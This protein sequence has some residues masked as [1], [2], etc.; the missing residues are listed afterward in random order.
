MAT[1]VGDKATLAAASLASGDYIVVIDTSSADVRI[2]Q[3]ADLLSV[4]ET[5][6]VADTTAVVKGSADATKQLRFEVDGFTSGATRVLTPPNANATI[7]G[8]EVAQTFTAAQTVAAAGA[9]V[10]LTDADGYF[11]A[12]PAEDDQNIVFQ[13]V[14][15]A[16]AGYGLQKVY[17]EYSTNDS[18]GNNSFRVVKVN[19]AGTELTQLRFDDDGWIFTGV[20]IT[21]T[22]V[23]AANSHVRIGAVG[24]GGVR[25][26]SVQSGTAPT[27][28]PTDC[29]QMWAADFAPGDARFY[30]RTEGGVTTEVA[31]LALANTWT[32]A[33][34][35]SSNSASAFA[36]GP[37][38]D[39]NPAFRVAANVA[40]A[41]TGIAVTGNAA[42]SHATISVISS[43]ANESLLLA[44]KGT[45]G[46]LF[47]DGAL[48]TPSIAFST[49]TNVG[50]FQQLAGTVVFVA[51]GTSYIQFSNAG[52]LA[53]GSNMTLGFCSGQPTAT[54]P[55]VGL[56]RDAAG[57]C[58]VSNGSTGLGSL[59]TETL[60]VRQSGGVAGTDEVQLSHDGA[61]AY[62]ESKDGPVRIRASTM[63]ASCYW[64]LSAVGSTGTLT[65]IGSGSDVTI[66]SE[67]GGGVAAT[68]FR[69]STNNFISFSATTGFVM[70]GS[71]GSRDVG[72]IRNEAGVWRVSNASTGLGS[73]LTG[74]L[75]EA[76]TAGSGSPNV[77]TAN[78]S[79]KTL[80]NEGATAQNYHTLPSAAAG[81][82]FEFI[83]QDA[84]G[85][86]VVAAAGDTIRDVGTVSAAAGYIQSTTVG[87]VVRLRAI[88]A[89]EWFVVYKQGTWTIDS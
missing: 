68:M 57:V 87:S 38:G 52:K 74:T 69:D 64:E 53:L 34:V 20:T 50:F 5:P 60:T 54:N 13:A 30:M 49:A 84:D 58:R 46:V 63:T 79:R 81:Y 85:I 70:G 41:A 75:V 77:L 19:S 27:T 40:S 73:L 51:G 2:V 48:S 80:T 9:A 89:T 7:A 72:L 67:S 45:G 11:E 71:G 47:P 65:Y 28:S 36:V 33:Q 59:L 44:P 4:I 14:P 23:L 78:E 18:A 42:G 37:N 35:I 25:V 15:V 82:D 56:A 83:V 12:T 62:L 10:R 22:G 16:G 26:L 29:V 55:D 88:N 31:G 39:T 1:Y 17:F 66:K 86:R 3:W 32:A 21:V 6:P 43:G 76:N 61:Y 24:S 8:L